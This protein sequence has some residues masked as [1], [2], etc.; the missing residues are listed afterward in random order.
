MKMEGTS[1]ENINSLMFSIKEL[2]AGL[3]VDEE[4]RNGALAMLAESNWE[5]KESI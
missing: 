2:I 5:S 3:N 1:N 4:T